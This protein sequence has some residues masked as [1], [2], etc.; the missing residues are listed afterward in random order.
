MED[1]NNERVGRKI[2]TMGLAKGDGRWDIIMALT[3]TPQ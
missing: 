1:G 2:C 3:Q